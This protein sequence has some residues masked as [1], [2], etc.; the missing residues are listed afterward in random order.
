[1]IRNTASGSVANTAAKKPKNS[2]GSAARQLF[3]YRTTLDGSFA[4]RA[5][6][7]SL[8]S[9]LSGPVRTMVFVPNPPRWIISISVSIASLPSD[10]SRT[11]TL[12]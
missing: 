4:N 11:I 5:M 12:A 1:M 10:A 9:S 6:R 7:R 3:L 2:R 8:T